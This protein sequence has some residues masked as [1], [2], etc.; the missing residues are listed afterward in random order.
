[1]NAAA[2]QNYKAASMLSSRCGEASAASHSKTEQSY[3]RIDNF[4]VLT[5]RPRVLMI[6][7]KGARPFRGDLPW[8]SGTKQ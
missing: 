8:T 2:K 7:L 6:A 4:S 5:C 1:M 3:A